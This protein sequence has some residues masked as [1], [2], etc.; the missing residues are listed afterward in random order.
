MTKQPISIAV[1]GAGVIGL[2]SAIRLL[3]AGHTVTIFAKATTPAT[4]SDIAAAYWAPHE[5][6]SQRRRAWTMRSLAVFLELSQEPTSGVDVV[7]LVELVDEPGVEFHDLGVATTVVPLGCFPAPWHGVQLSAPR[8]DVPTYMPWLTQRFFTLGGTLHQVEITDLATL[9]NDYRWLV[10]C[11]GLGA[12]ALTGDK[13]YPIRGQVMRVRRPQDFPPDIISASSATATTYIVP[14][15]NDCLLGGTFQFHNGDM[16]IDPQTAEGILQ[17][18]TALRPALQGAEILEHRVGLRPGR[19]AVRLEREQLTNGSTVI[20]N[21]G[22]AAYGHTLSW[23]CAEE[24][25]RMAA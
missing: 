21:Y 10:N 14:R 19:R 4:T 2:T 8:I 20:H 22:H 25:V 12:K 24:V 23:G 9:G 13:L 15:R 3:E 16:R 5:Y 6:S 7:P 1:I 18:C 17:R 11:T